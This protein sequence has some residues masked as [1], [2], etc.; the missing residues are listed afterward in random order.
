MC[1]NKCNQGRWPCP[2]RTECAQHEADYEDSLTLLARSIVVP[3][4]LVLGGLV[5]VSIIINEEPPVAE[6]TIIAPATQGE[7]N[8]T[9]QPH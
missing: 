6:S 8:V 4:T 5:A 2:N 9:H 1:Q 7:N 3:I